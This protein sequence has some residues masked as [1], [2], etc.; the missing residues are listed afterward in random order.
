MAAGK[1]LLAGAVAAASRTDIELQVASHSGWLI[2][3]P[4]RTPSHVSQNPVQPR[5][6]TRALDGQVVVQATVGV[7]LT[8][9]QCIAA[10]R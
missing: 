4:T 5:A 1:L 10:G 3:Q 8:I 7:V 6:L 9:L 2:D